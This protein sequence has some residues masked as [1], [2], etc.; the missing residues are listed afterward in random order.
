MIKKPK[1]R[2]FFLMLLCLV[3]FFG[4]LILSK[5]NVLEKEKLEIGKEDVLV[6]E[7]RTGCTKYVN[8]EYGFSFCYPFGLS[9]PE[10]EEI[11]PPQQW[12]YNLKLKSVDK[13]YEVN[14]YDQML[15]NTLS[16]FIRNY[17]S[18]VDSGPVDFFEREINGQKA[19]GCF[20]VKESFSPTVSIHLGFQKGT[21][22]LIF[23][24][25][26][27]ALSEKENFFDEAGFKTIVEN[28]TWI[29]E[30]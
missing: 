5:S 16:N 24:S 9:L 19:V 14:L 27:E 1:S 30:E 8:E 12:L 6:E 10:E 29:D 20:F 7:K 25:P 13:V 22:I 23:S 17:F 21:K 28:F 11:L 18:S 2:L 26:E 4:F 15:P 3:F